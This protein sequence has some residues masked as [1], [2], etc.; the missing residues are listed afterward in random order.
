MVL[1]A[2]VTGEFCTVEDFWCY[3]N[4]MR[5]PSGLDANSNYHIFKTG[6]KPMWEDPH[7]AKGGKWI[8]QL[9]GSNKEVR[10]PFFFPHPFPL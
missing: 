2:N 1:I 3:Y 4:N 6:V 9:K 5:R 8:L 10:A 7:N